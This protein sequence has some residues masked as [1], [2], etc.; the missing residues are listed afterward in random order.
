MWSVPRGWI[1]FLPTH[2]GRNNI[3][4][5]DDSKDDDM[6]KTK[7]LAKMNTELPTKM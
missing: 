1:I 7:S 5:D 6:A 3:D 4:G 2:D